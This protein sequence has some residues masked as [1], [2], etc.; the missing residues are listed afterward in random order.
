MA[1]THAY[2]TEDADAMGSMMH[3]E[4]EWF[5]VS[6]ADIETVISGRDAL[7]A[8]MREYFEGDL[9]VT[10]TLSGWSRNGPYVGVTETAA[11]TAADGTLQKQSSLAVYEITPENL[12]R[13]VWYFPVVK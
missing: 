2:N 11:W 9:K 6:G 1:F 4:F 10:S 12:I 5:S 7:V 3:S 13:R 8:D